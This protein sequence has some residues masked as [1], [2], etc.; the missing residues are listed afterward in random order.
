VG[1]GAATRAQ[2]HPLEGQLLDV[3]VVFEVDELITVQ[4][5]RPPMKPIEV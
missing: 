5:H 4:V 3:R 2:C 1:D